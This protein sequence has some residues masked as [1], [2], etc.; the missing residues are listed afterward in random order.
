MPRTHNLVA[1]ND[2]LAQWTSVMGAFVL[3]DSDI[4]VVIRNAKETAAKANFASVA[5][6]RQFTPTA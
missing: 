5:G 3:D 2:S 6:W 4:S 1:F